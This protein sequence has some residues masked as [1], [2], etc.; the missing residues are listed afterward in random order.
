M[1]GHT[2]SHR[3]STLLWGEAKRVC[4]LYLKEDAF[5]SLQVLEDKLVCGS[6]SQE[7]VLGVQL[8]CCIQFIHLVHCIA[9]YNLIKTYVVR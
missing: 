4:F 7:H 5:T 9:Y 1:D 2:I 8:C 3:A 6:L